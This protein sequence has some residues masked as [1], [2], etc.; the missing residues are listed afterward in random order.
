MRLIHQRSY[1]G[2]IVTIP[3]T[4]LPVFDEIDCEL[5]F[6]SFEDM[7]EA[8]YHD[9]KERERFFQESEGTSEYRS[10]L[11]DGRLGESGRCGFDFRSL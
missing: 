6:A 7:L 10:M 9:A 1:I 5:Q 2:E 11:F 4:S 8:H 3:F